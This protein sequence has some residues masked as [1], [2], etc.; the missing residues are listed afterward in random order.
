MFGNNATAREK[1]ERGIME[2][3]GG[4]RIER[5][6]GRG[7]GRGG[8]DCEVRIRREEEGRKRREK[9]DGKGK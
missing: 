1:E 5:W 3:E 9:K 2:R 8:S 7:R 6:G 4:R